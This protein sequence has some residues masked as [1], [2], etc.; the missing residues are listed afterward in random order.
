MQLCLTPV[1]IIDRETCDVPAEDQVQSLCSVAL[2]LPEKCL[3]CQTETR[4]IEI[5][6][7]R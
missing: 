7:Y 1:R 5:I 3:A 4:D 2:T 6:A